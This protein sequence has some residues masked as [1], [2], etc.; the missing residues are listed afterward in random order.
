MRV[1]RIT[2]DADLGLIHLETGPGGDGDYV[3]LPLEV[4]PTVAGYLRL[5]EES[6]ITES[7]PELVATGGWAVPKG[8]VVDWA[9]EKKPKKSKK[10]KGAPFP[11]E[12]F[13]GAVRGGIKYPKPEGCPTCRNGEGWC[14]EHSKAVADEA[15]KDCGC[16][17]CRF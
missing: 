13:P 9:V 4:P 16:S 17:G 1:R 15:A 7:G 10:K 3:L 2:I 5:P 14:K 11:I 6:S 12:S 8:Q